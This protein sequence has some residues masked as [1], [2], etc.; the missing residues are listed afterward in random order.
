MPQSSWI[1][2]CSGATGQLV[3]HATLAAS[4]LFME[5]SSTCTFDVK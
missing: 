2:V 1:D 4:R 3:Q 5:S